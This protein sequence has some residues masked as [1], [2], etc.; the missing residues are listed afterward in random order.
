MDAIA[1][2]QDQTMQQQTIFTLI[3]Q[4][5][6]WEITRRSRW[7]TAIPLPDTS[8]EGEQAASLMI[9]ICLIE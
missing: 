2:S 8:G 6:S 4:S 5:P 3:E 1:T 9:K 7:T